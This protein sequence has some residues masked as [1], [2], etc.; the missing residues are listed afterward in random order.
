MPPPVKWPGP[1]PHI[2]ELRCLALRAQPSGG[3]LWAKTREPTISTTPSH[4]A[5]ADIAD[6]A[7]EAGIERLHILAWRDLA[8]VEAGGSEIHAA[9]MA[10]IWAASGLDI[11]MRTSHAQGHPPR[12]DRDGYHVIRRA[13]RYDVFP[14]TIVSEMLGTYGPRDAIVE[15]WNGV[16]FLSPVWFRGPKLVFIHHVHHKM[17]DM[18]LSE[19]LAKFGKA[20]EGQIAPP[21]YKKVPIVTPSTSAAD[22]VTELLRIPRDH[23]SVASPGIDPMFEPDGDVSPHP[24]IVSVGRLMPPKRFDEMIR[25]AAEVRR[26]HPTLEYVIVGDGYERPHLQQIIAE[27]D[28]SSWVHLRGRVSD[29]ELVYLYRRAWLVASA[30]SAEGW[31]MTMTEAAACGTP[32]VASRIA[33]H[34]DSVDENVSGLLADSSREMVEK[35]ALVLS[36]DDLRTRLGEGARKHAA[37]YTW[38]AC[39]LNAFTPLAESVIKSRSR[40]RALSGGTRRT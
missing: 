27:L 12:G 9:K 5:R 3:R 17:W 7:A 36:D 33:G 35:I 16:P 10:A 21:F 8:D 30:S 26:T 22:E 29:E 24:L 14:R 37:A 20:L 15:V 2:A 32:V 4:P 23:I 39:A 31:G 40:S 11:T 19:R 34:C 28:A 18:V 25:I 13:G 38:E 1:A 6:L